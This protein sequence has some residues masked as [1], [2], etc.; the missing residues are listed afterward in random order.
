MDINKAI[1][2]QKKSYKGFMLAMCFIFF[3]MPVVLYLSE[4]ITPFFIFYLA[5]IEIMVLL[6][7]LL[8]YNNEKL[9][10]YCD[11]EKIKIRDGLI[12]ASYSLACDKVVLVHSE[13]VETDIELIILTTSRFRNKKIKEIDLEFLKKH[14][15]LSHEYTRIKKLYPENNYYYIIIKSG[16][17]Y[18]YKLLIDTYKNCVKA[19]FTDEAIEN[20]KKARG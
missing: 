9:E 15:Y 7:I 11:S 14:V 17:Y 16:G 1:R 13:K 3:I 6:S 20:I 18:K 19:T 10:F 8:R 2:K 5:I 12:N 4:K